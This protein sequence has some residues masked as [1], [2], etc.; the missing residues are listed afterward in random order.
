MPKI[1]ID[2][3]NYSELDVFLKKHKA[4]YGGA[5]THTSISGNRGSFYIPDKD[6]NDFFNIYYNHVFVNKQQA[7][8]TEG[9]RDCYVTPVKIDLDFRL[10]KNTDKEIPDKIYELE[11]I[12]KICQRYISVMENWLVSPDTKERYCFILEKP[13]ARYDMDKS[14]NIKLNENGEKRI[15]DGVHIM[16]PYITTDIELQLIFRDNIYKNVGDIFDKYNYDESYA[17]IFDKAVIDRNN[18]QMY[19]SNK[20]VGFETYKVTKIIEVY[21]DS[22]KEIPLDNYT[23][24]LLI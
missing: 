21:S 15:K 20:G 1:T 8:L 12:I 9:I 6:L 23:N 13:H 7:Y 16:F 11:D 18:W 22:Y 2:I 17:D 5:F 24:E 10:Y 14:G 3:H 19:G 4:S